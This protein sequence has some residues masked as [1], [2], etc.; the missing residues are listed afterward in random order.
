MAPALQAAEAEAEVKTALQIVSFQ[1]IAKVNSFYWKTEVMKSP[2]KQPQ[3]TFSSSTL[4]PPVEYQ[5][6]KMLTLMLHQGEEK[7]YQ[8]VAKV[9]LPASAKQTIVVLIP[10]PKGSKLP[11]RAIAMNAGL[12][13]FKPGSRRVINLSK[14]PIRGEMGAK[15]F[16][17][18][19]KKNVRFL[20][21]P[22]KI[23]DVPALNNHAKVWASHPVILEYH[24]AHNKWHVLSSSRWFHTPSQRHL[25]FVYYDTV[26]SNIILRG[27]SDS[28]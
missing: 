15:P 19:G 4:L 13:S 20:C 27:I 11:L 7:G 17:R 24:G 12:K 18:G 6:P 1:P 16:T 21:K 25:V 3:V 28:I 9:N 2:D 22:N 5:G 26:R 10:T 14:A 23:V 8:P